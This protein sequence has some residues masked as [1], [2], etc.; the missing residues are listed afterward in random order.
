MANYANKIFT[1]YT[2]MTLTNLL[3]SLLQGTFTHTC[4]LLLEL[5]HCGPHFDHHTLLFLHH[6]LSSA[7]LLTDNSQLLGLGC[8]DDGWRRYSTNAQ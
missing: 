5:L 4:I 3:C 2:L 8:S 6:S 1:L 7:G